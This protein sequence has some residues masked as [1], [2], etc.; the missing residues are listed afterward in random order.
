MKRKLIFCLILV[1]MMLCF[2]G[3]AQAS[4]VVIDG[5]SLVF[6][7]EPVIIK[8]RVLVPFRG[9]FEALDAD[10]HWYSDTGKVIAHK[11]NTTI[12]I[13]IGGPTL[14]N[15]KP[16]SLD[17]PP[18]IIRGR[19]MV[20]IR[21]VSEALGAQVHWDKARQRVYHRQKRSI[22]YTWSTGKTTASGRWI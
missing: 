12:E 2:G 13:T 6:D 4:Q 19:T 11:G 21:F 16:V 8:G 10:V 3:A 18:R 9:I 17:V 14:K 20:P 5:K 22:L 7:A 1:T 15:G